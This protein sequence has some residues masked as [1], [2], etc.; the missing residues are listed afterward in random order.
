MQ[1]K[2]IITVDL[3]GTKILSALLNDDKEIVERYKEAT[4]ITGDI[5]PIINGI[6]NS[7][8]NLL[9]KTS[10]TERDITAVCLGVPG[11]VNPITGVIGNA[12]NL[13]IID[14]NIKE[15]LGEKINIPI[16]IEN[17]V[18]LAG[19]GIKYFELANKVNNMLVVFVGTGI[20]AALFFNG[21]I[22]RGSSFFAGE[23]GHMLVN[24]KGKLGTKSKYTFETTASRTAVVN[25]I[26]SEIK[27]GKS[28]T[29]TSIVKDG[30]RI[31]SKMLKS[32][33]ESNDKLVVKRL[34]KSANV[35]GSVLGSITTLLNLDTIILGGGVIE[36]MNDFMMPKIE[37]SFKKSVLT[38]PGKIVKID[39][40]KLGDDAP[41]YGGLAL[42]QELLDN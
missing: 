15:A 3:G 40:T 42:A 37:K 30:K 29:L 33:V 28:S 12:P 34:S 21:N 14:F 23:I 2:Y 19:L 1:K 26:I 5:K 31:K 6:A 16:L 32:A 36:A 7:V 22:Y 4:K 11:T 27:K 17:D 41:L 13:G 8:K 24:S 9:K 10:L 38:E 35:I 20:G 18:N 25:T 39:Y